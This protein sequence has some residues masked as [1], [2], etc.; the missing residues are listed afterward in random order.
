LLDRPPNGAEPRHICSTSASLDRYVPLM[1]TNEEI[2]Q[3]V[4]AKFSDGEP[5]Q[6]IA[7]ANEARTSVAD[8]TAVLDDAVVA[9]ELTVA[10][11]TLDG[12]R[13]RVFRYAHR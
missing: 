10:E 8:V 3:V 7:V 12:E 9:E 11:E 6:P 1:V 2:M 13:V 5:F 4:R